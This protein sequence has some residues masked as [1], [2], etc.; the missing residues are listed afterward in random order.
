MKMTAQ[1]FEF[2]AD[3][4]APKL[5][6]PSHIQQIAD[7]LAK[8][9]PKFDSVKF[10]NRAERAW[11]NEVYRLNPQAHPIQENDDDIPY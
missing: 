4:I 1:H 10:C 3:I 8:T 11:W 6:W 2:I 5:S 7:E 9:N